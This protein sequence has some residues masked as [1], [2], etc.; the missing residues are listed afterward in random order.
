M[1]DNTE[2][3]TLAQWRAIERKTGWAVMNTDEDAAHWDRGADGWQK[4]IDFEKKFSQ[5]QVD[6]MTRITSDD[7]VLDACCG[8]GRLTIPIARRARHVYAVDAGG[9]MLEH[10]RRNAEEAGLDNVTVNRISNWHRCSPAEEI[11]VADIA[12]ACISPAQADIVKFS[13]CARKYCYS[14]SFTGR[15]YRFFMAELFDGVNDFWGRAGKRPVRDEHVKNRHR[16]GVNIPF[17]ILYELGA[18]PEIKYVDGGWEYEAPDREQV[19]AYLAGL[20]ADGVP[21][22]RMDRFRSNCD[23][24][25][26]ETPE[27]TFRY[28]AGTRMYVLGWDPSQLD[29]DRPGI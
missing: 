8:T 3:A 14:L 26:T 27:G 2:R 10:C 19:Y 12:V 18:D 16:D 17:N 5:A 25:I 11:P 7:T 24:R 21:A 6:A 28:F 9:H 4:R 1:T 20:S 22:D 13:R 15:P 29:L 23:R